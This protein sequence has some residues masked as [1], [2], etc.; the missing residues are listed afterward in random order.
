[1]YAAPAK[2]EYPRLV[3]IPITSSFDDDF[4]LTCTAS[5]SGD[6]TVVWSNDGAYVDATDFYI[7]T[8]PVTGGEYMY[9]QTDATNSTLMSRVAQKARHFTCYNI[10]QYEGNYTCAASTYAVGSKIPDVSKAFVVK[11]LCKFAFTFTRCLRIKN[12]FIDR[13]PV[14]RLHII[15]FPLPI[16]HCIPNKQLI[17][18][19]HVVGLC[20]VEMYICHLSELFSLL[21]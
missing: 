5:G 10:T 19:Q 17:V 8:L 14:S 21:E 6:V 15:V 1:M 9:G 13:R 12:C 16:Q 18:S 4:S 11:V 2:I 20:H 3:N 7:T